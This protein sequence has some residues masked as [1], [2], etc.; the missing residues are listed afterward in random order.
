MTFEIQFN[1]D[2]GVTIMGRITARNG[3]GAATGED[4]EGN[5]LQQADI[6]SITLA[7]F[8]LEAP[9]TTYAEETLVVGDTILDTPVSTNVIWTKDSVG[10][11]FIHDLAASN[12]PTGG[13]IVRAEYKVTLAGGNVVFGVYEGP[14][15]GINTS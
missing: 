5:W 11:N 8:D 1:E 6:S 10:Y 2:S 14:V 3:S 15:C 9:T 4:G 7:V 12:F 13:S